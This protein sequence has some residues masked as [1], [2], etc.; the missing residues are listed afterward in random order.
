MHFIAIIIIAATVFATGAQ[1]AHQMTLRNNCGFAVD[2]KLSNWPGHPAYTGPAIGRLNAKTSKAV[3]VPDGW[4]GRI[5]DGAGGCGGGDC[6]GK[7][8]MTEFNMNANG[9]N[10][11]DISNIQAYTVPQKI[12]SSCGSVACTSPSCPCDQAYGIGNTAGTCPGSSTPDRPVRACGQP[13]F[14]ITYCP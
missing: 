12:E 7:C 3:T 11:Y 2:L 14:T 10:Y 8:S 1:A 6:Y 13:N 9:L 5:C 4:D